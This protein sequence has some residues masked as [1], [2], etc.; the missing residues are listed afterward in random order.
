MEAQG[1]L[2]LRADPARLPLVLLNPPDNP[3]RL[4]VQELAKARGL[5]LALNAAMFKSDY[6]TSIGYMKNG[7]Y[8]NNGAIASKLKGFLAFNPKRAGADPVKIGGAELVK[9]YET[10]FQTWRMWTPQGGI[11]WNKGAQIHHQVALVGVDNQNRVLFFFHPAE[12]DM[13][14]Y[15][16]EIVSLN[17]GLTGLLYL[18]GGTH[19]VF[20][21]APDVGRALN[22]RQYL[23]NILGLMHP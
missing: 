14:D 7:A 4:D 13:H 2:I 20:Y 11:L 22:A 16:A 15:V 8:V 3:Q 10:V 18:D 12:I 5:A 9:R 19:G 21:Q 1:I 6:A 17:L 23:P